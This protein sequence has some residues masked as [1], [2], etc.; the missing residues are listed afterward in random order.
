MYDLC[1]N[2]KNWQKSGGRIIWGFCVFYSN[3]I[4]FKDD[5]ETIIIQRGD[6]FAS[7]SLIQSADLLEIELETGISEKGEKREN[8]KKNKRGGNKIKK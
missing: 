5:R 7:L 6:D 8:V 1:E 4:K 3:K 2:Q